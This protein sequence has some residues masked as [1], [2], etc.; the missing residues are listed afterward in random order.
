MALS[1]CEVEYAAASSTVCEAIWLRNIL[2]ELDH[3]QEEATVLFVDN[4]LAIQLAKNQCIV[5]EAS[6]VI[7]P[8]S[9]RSCE[10]EDYRATILPH[11]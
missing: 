6:I 4:K 1:S 2:K 11:Y 7:L 8:L 10:R 9:S 3:S 5:E